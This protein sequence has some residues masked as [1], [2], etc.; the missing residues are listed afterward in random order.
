MS[1]IKSGLT[2]IA[3]EILK[4]I[5]SEA[6]GII[7]DSEKEAKEILKTAKQ[8]ADKVYEEAV[9]EANLKASNEKRRIQSLTEIEK[10]NRLLKLKED[11]VEKAFEQAKAKLEDFV[12]TE[13][14]HDFLI[15]LIKKGVKILPSKEILIQVNSADEE[16]LLS[17]NNLKH[18][19]KELNI[20]FE[21]AETNEN[22]I[23]GCK[24]QTKDQKLQ[25]DSTI[26]NRIDTLKP[27][28][29]IQIAKIL[30]NKEDEENVS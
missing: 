17:H 12:K 5:Q 29:R 10:R 1:D 27:I 25:Y 24:M 16:W 9:Q 13:D 6:Q 22:F 7:N 15:E 23:G 4:D 3:A 26:E 30:F 21:V 20:Q 28:L 18:L 14:Y 2:A 11:L 19:S 8:E